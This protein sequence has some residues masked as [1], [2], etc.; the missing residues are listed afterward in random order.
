MPTYVCRSRPGVLTDDARAALAGRITAVH[1]TAT[2]APPSFVQVIFD[3]LPAGS[4][5]IGGRPADPRSVFVHGHI[6]TGRAA[7]VR[8]SVVRGVRDA[9]TAVTGLPADVVWVYLSEIPPAQM[10]EFGRVL[11]EPGGEQEWTDALPERLRA[12]LRDLDGS[13]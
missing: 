2:S 7:E 8:T 11:P 4:H 3:D 9:V 5:H 6:R 1:A 10:I 12:H 13:A